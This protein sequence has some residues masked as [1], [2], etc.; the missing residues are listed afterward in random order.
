VA[1]DATSIDIASTVVTVSIRGAGISI[2]YMK[3]SAA[4]SLLMP[5]LDARHA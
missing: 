5:I 1:G 4:M 2:P 3:Q